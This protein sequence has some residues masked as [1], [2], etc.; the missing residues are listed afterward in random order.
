MRRLLLGV[1]GHVDHGKTALVRTLTGTD[2]DR[3]AEE[4]RRGISIVL[5]FAHFAQGEAE[6]DLIDMPGHERFVRTM[7]AGATGIDGV[8]LVVAANEGVRPQTVEHVQI[9]ALLGIKRAVIAVSKADLASP[10]DAAAVCVEAARLAASAGLDAPAPV[11]TSATQGEGI[12]ELRAAI[13][14]RLEGAAAPPDD[15]FSWLPIDRAFSRAGHGTIVTGTLRRGALSVG[16]ELALLPARSPSG[17]RPVRV[18]ALQVHGAAVASAAAGQRVAVN[19]RGVEAAS[20]ARGDA[21]A[22]GGLLRPAAWLSV[23]LRLLPDAPELASGARVQLLAGTAEVAARLRLLDR[24]V[25]ESGG[26]APAQLQCAVPVALPSRERFVIRAASPARTLGGGRVLDAEAT[27]LRRHAS[28]V[29]RRLAALAAE[30]PGQTLGREIAEAGAA[31]RSLAD[32]AHRVGL[33]PARAMAALDGAP[34]LV[35][36]GAAVDRSAFEA[37][38]RALPV[39]AGEHGMERDRLADALRTSPPVLEEALARLVA[40]GAVRQEGGRVRQVR[41]EQEAARAEG[42]ARLAAELAERLRRAGLSPPDQKQIAAM[43][44]GAARTLAELAR[45]GVL[46]RTYDRVQRRQI[47]FHRD[48]VRAAQ[49]ALAPLLARPPGL[50]VSEAGAALGISRKFSVPLL[51]YFDAIQYTRRVADR[52]VLA[53]RGA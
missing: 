24:D 15:G 30:T 10:A 7:I 8:L 41:A 52:R 19:L 32:V 42:D 43:H 49:R 27:R 44:P 40:S 4:K 12:A 34:V 11:L 35:V 28:A 26:T 18:R 13:L 2:T 20:V 37:L 14:S 46:V 1:I 47:L 16:E 48:A 21:L 17:G 51:E 23:M 9:A 6:I 39:R 33:S 3:L 31:G 29:L 22:A 25:L 5:G 53:D 38:L 50:L 36:R 45:Q